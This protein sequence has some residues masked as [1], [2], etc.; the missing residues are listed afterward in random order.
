MSRLDSMV[1]VLIVQITVPLAA[2]LVLSLRRSHSAASRSLVWGA[3]AALLLTPC[4]FLP[5]PAWTSI[6]NENRIVTYARTETEAEPAREQQPEPAST[7]R[8]GPSGEG[9]DLLQLAKSLR[10][11]PAQLQSRQSSTKDWLTYGIAGL[12]ALSLLR[13][14][15]GWISL[16][17]TRRQSLALIDGNLQSTLAELRAELGC[18]RRIEL[19]ESSRIGSAA[20][21]GWFRP[22]ILLST[23]WRTWTAV[24][25]RAILAHEVGHV[26][27]RDF[28]SRFLARLAGVIHGYH[29]LVQWLMRRLELRQEMAADELA[30]NCVGGRSEYLRCLASLALKAD[31]V[32]VGAAPTFLSRPRTLLRR[33]AMLQ[34]KDDKRSWSSG[35]WGA[36]IVCVFSV[37]ALGLH[38]QSSEAVATP[39]TPTPMPVA[40][41]PGFDISLLDLEDNPENV[42]FYSLRLGKYNI[43]FG[44]PS[45]D[46]IGPMLLRADSLPVSWVNSFSEIE[47]VAGRVS[48]HVDAD[49]PAPNHRLDTSLSLLRFKHDRDWANDIKK[50]FE[51]VKTCKCGDETYFECET[52]KSLQSLLGSLK[53]INLYPADGRTLFIAES[54]KEIKKFIDRKKENNRKPKWYDQWRQVEQ[55]TFAF[56]LTD[57]QKRFKG[58]LA[59]YYL[60]PKMSA[61]ER[62]RASA[63][64]KCV[65][66]IF[67]KSDSVVFGLDLG[68]S[69]S[70]KIRLNAATSADMPMISEQC[71]SIWKVLKSQLTADS[72]KKDG[73]ASAD[74]ERQVL[75][76]L[77][78]KPSLRLADQS[79]IIDSESVEAMEAINKAIQEFLQMMN[80]PR[81]VPKK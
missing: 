52:P 42:G 61:D 60:D 23:A 24:E 35:W 20:T 16:I 69:L 37:L 57:V 67:S 48:I 56:V 51:K 64:L 62:E 70:L 31:D 80:E 4:A 2:A 58:K 47:Q 30:A 53:T 27:R 49:K 54:E 28:P 29:P 25:C 38:G 81:P 78:K 1:V 68:K 66:K 77:S 22:K 75:R 5:I 7:A 43:V 11:E 33:I 74:T 44:L 40:E 59:G 15:M 3:A 6:P 39:E 71:E 9:I 41:E 46:M 76:G 8:G 50:S 34:V 79:I 10:I 18:R 65:E 14:G 19:R 36:A 21:V 13:F 63:Q 17:R 45:M 12:A 26:L 73:D 32:T 72:T 55:D